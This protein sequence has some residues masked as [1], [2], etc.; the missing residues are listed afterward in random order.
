[1]VKDFS[2]KTGPK[3]SAKERKLILLC[4][5]ELSHDAFSQMYMYLS[6]W[7]KQFIVSYR[8]DE[9]IIAYKWKQT[10]QLYIRIG[11]EELAYSIAGT[12]IM[13]FRVELQSLLERLAQA[14]KKERKSIIQ[15]IKQCNIAICKIGD[16]S[17]MKNVADIVKVKS[18][19]ETFIDKLDSDPY[20]IN[21]K[22]VLVDIRTDE[23]RDRVP[24]DYF[25]RTLDYDYRD[26]PNPKKVK[27]LRTI[28]ENTLNNNQ[29]DIRAVLSYFG[30][31]M[32]GHNFEQIS[33]WLIG[34]LACNG[35]STLI[36]MFFLMFKIYCKKI[37]NKTFERGFTKHHKQF[38]EV[39]NRRLV[40]LEEM[41]RKNMDLELF[42]DLIADP[43]LGSNEVMFGT[44]KDIPISFCFVFTSNNNPSFQ[45]DAG[46]PRRGMIVETNSQF[47][48]QEKYDKLI[49]KYNFH[50]MDKNLLKMIGADD[51]CKLALFHIFY[52]YTKKY[53]SDNKL[54]HSRKPIL[55]W[56]EICKQND[57]MDS[58]IEQFYIITKEASDVIHKDVFLNDYKKYTGLGNL[59]FNN[60]LNDIK[61]L[62][63]TYDR[64]KQ[65]SK[66]RGC[67]VGIKRNDVDIPMRKNIDTDQ[68]DYDD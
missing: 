32:V 53:M 33:L 30:Y 31:C 4:M 14:D 13:T 26:E 11:R 47:I 44:T 21:F 57:T 28:I 20:V 54:S 37:S 68:L 10:T 52:E 62:Q 46:I 18:I 16:I 38:A 66:L 15:S 17:F 49:D 35:K 59:S 9:K 23:I 34:A 24:T 56:K 5:G 67:L 58:F 3:E 43:V 1:M 63:I 7:H 8:I 61:R 12:I 19:D 42:K 22:N 39:M 55:R 60:V 2:K 65:V 29:K 45:N 64:M 25:S 27:K 48:P 51:E 36:A 50:P 40:F 41:S 6:A